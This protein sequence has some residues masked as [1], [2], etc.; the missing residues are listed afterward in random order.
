MISIFNSFNLLPSKFYLDS[1]ETNNNTFDVYKKFDSIFEKSCISESSY[2][3]SKEWRVFSK[4]AYANLI[5]LT[6]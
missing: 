6:H 4:L 3:V 2:L 1:N 5:I